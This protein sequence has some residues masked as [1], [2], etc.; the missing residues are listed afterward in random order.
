MNLSRATLH[1]IKQCSRKVALRMKHKHEPSQHHAFNRNQPNPT[2]MKKVIDFLKS[3]TL[4]FLT[5]VFVLIA[6]IIHSMY[7]FERIRVADMSFHIGGYHITALNW[8]HALIFSV[9]IESAILM[10]ILNGKRLPSKIYAVASFA[11]NILYYGTWKLDYPEMVATVIASS[12]LAGSIWFFSD[13]FAEKIEL[14]PFGQSQE[15]LKK[16]LAAQELEERNKM[17][18]K[19]VM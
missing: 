11:T 2:Y 5:L 7:I 18:F 1:F 15:E 16:F 10:F 17:T 19:K 3:E 4:V 9:A 6:Q 13:L 12:M 8:T 14:L